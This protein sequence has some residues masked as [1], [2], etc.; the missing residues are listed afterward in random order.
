MPG[1]G[2]GYRPSRLVMS[3]ADHSIIYIHRGRNAKSIAIG[4][5][6]TQRDYNFDYRGGS[7]VLLLFKAWIASTEIPKADVYF[8]EGALC[9]WPA[10]FLK[11]KYK[12]A[13]ILMMV[14]EPAFYLDPRRN[15]LQK[16]LFYW[17]MWLY[18]HVFGFIVVSEMVKADIQRYCK[19]PV[20][21]GHHFVSNIERF[22]PLKSEGGYQIL[23][24]CDRPSE[25]G[26]IKGLAETIAIF[27]ELNMLL[28]E[29][30]LVI[31]GAGSDHL[32]FSHPHIRA[33][34][35]VDM[36]DIIPTCRIILAPAKYDAFP[37]AVV[38]CGLVGVVPVISSH[39]GVKEIIEPI[40]PELVIYSNATSDYVAVIRSVLEW[41]DEKYT[42][43]MQKLRKKLQVLNEESCLA[44]YRD[45]WTQL[46]GT[47]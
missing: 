30:R 45:A 44:E 15:F 3:I 1:I 28:P 32:S 18:R 41:P 27:T 2:G 26:Y 9:F 46:L 38:E 21:I 7:L 10:Y 39:V 19:Q 43:V 14:P 23:F 11:K 36:T 47:R 5:A 12:T 17:R 31:V 6:L 16:L 13:K 40:C 34:G 25:T 37:L 20:L 22:L 4:K 29:T 33:L 24:V 35:H 8:I 42:D